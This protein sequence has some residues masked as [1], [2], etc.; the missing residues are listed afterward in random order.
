[1]VGP[2]VTVRCPACGAPLRAVLAPSPPTQWFPCSQCRAPVPVVVPRDPPPLYSWEVVPGLYPA[3]PAPRIPK[4]RVRPMAAGSLLGVAVV[5]LVLAGS[6]AYY[7]VVA[8]APGSFDARGTVSLAR[9]SGGAV[10]AGGVAVVATPESG[11]AVPATTAADGT[12]YLAGLPTGGVTLRF[13]DPGYSTVVVYAFVSTLYTAGATGLEVTLSK[14]SANNTTA[15]GLTPF[16]DLEQ[17]VAAIG[18]GVVLLGFV[19]VLAIYTALL[20][21]RSDRPTFG[22][23]GGGAGVLAPVALALLAL[24]APFPGLLA[25]SAAL[26]VFGGFALS[27]RGVQMAQTGPAAS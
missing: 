26:A 16:S 22:V 8:S 13:T 15:F 10:P 24:G 17:F 23:V 1:M 7:A 4:W 12:F 20:T 14:G 27:V 11:A 19:A 18:A 9:P 25:G 2:A 5:A 3:L 6:F 21:L